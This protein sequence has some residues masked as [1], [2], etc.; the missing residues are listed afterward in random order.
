MAVVG[1][2]AL[3]DRELLRAA[4]EAFD[5]IVTVDRQLAHAGPVPGRLA[6]V[7][8]VSVSNRVEDLDP[9]VPALRAALARPA[10]GAVTVVRR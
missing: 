9:L 6:V 2:A 8:L 1:W 4:A 10:W 5:V 3:P 7:L